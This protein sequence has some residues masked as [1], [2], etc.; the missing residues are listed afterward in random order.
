M[1]FCQTKF[2]FAW[3]LGGGRPARAVARL[4]SPAMLELSTGGAQRAE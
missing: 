4:L 1:H 2:R 3:L